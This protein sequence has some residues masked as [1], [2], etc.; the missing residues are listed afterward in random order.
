MNFIS[1]LFQQRKP[2]SSGTPK[3]FDGD[4]HA[5]QIV[6]DKHTHQTRDVGF[7]P[8]DNSHSE[9]PD[10]FEYWPIQKFLKSHPLDE[11]AVYGFFS[12]RFTEKTSL[13]SADVFRFIET[14]PDADVYIFSPFPCHGAFFLNVFEQHDY[15]CRGSLPLANQVWQNIG[16]NEG[17]E[18][19][20]NHSGTVIYSNFFLAK[21]RFWREWLRVCGILFEA[22]EKDPPGTLLRQAL[23]YEKDDGTGYKVEQKVFFM[24]RVASFLLA[25]NPSFVTQNYPIQKLP[26]SDMGAGREGVIGQMDA[27]KRQMQV[28]FSDH[29]LQEFRELQ[30][31]VLEAHTATQA[32]Q[33]VPSTN[34]TYYDNVN[35]T[36]F[37][38]ISP[39]ASS[40]CEFGCGAGGMA[41]AVRNKL[42]DVHY[43]G[44][45]LVE[46]ELNKAQDVLS[47]SVCC[48]LDE[49]ANWLPG[50]ALSTVLAQR[51]FD[52]MIFGDVLEHLYDP[53]NT[54]RNA[55]KYLK[56][57]G[58]ALLCIPNVQHWSVFA[59]LVL[60]T[61]PRDD[62][63]LF[64]RTHIRWFTL[65]DMVLLAEAAGLK[66]QTIEPRIFDD[67][68][69]EAVME[70]LEPLAHYLGVDPDQL[71]ERGKAL[72]Y[73]L[74][75]EKPV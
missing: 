58:K 30:K 65:D 67:P 72:Q 24:E 71:I 61:W 35:M 64:D 14:S 57:G 28:S 27:L 15:F 45:E 34:M 40:I 8:L 73:V 53:P 31:Q 62:S 23:D 32:E 2:A 13:T 6:Y 42:P 21:P 10:W 39:H 11:D 7:E 12:P 63:G 54:L 50:A 26:V 9:R 49:V 19:L 43:V 44:V 55:V 59:N 3:C 17:L 1:N 47:E 48:N 52:H 68:R 18:N 70:D 46:S 41:R 20:L 33:K 38:H 69:A 36:L 5:F 16:F 75:A 29:L 37:N 22:A 74:V 4:V 60:G 25:T 56:P 66:V 51:S